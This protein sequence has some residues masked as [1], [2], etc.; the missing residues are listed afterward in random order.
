MARNSDWFVALFTP[1]VI[2][3]TMEL[4]FPQFLKT[5]LKG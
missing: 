5:A 2:G 1:V 3:I 4:V